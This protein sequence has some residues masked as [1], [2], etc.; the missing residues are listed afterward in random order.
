MISDVVIQLVSGDDLCR[1]GQD[2]L[3]HMVASVLWD[4]GVLGDEELQE[5]GQIIA[6]AKR[7][8]GAQKILVHHPQVEVVAEGMD[9]HQVP[10]LVTFLGEEH[11]QLQRDKMEK[12]LL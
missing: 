4:I 6:L 3:V 10:H 7:H 2:A 1:D 9:V 8:A 5:A 12:V 11:G